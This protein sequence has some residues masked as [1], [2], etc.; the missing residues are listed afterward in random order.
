MTLFDEALKEIYLRTTYIAFTPLGEIH[1]RI[2][3]DNQLLDQLLI[4]HGVNDWCFVTAWNPYSATA[5]KEDNLRWN[6]ALEQELKQSFVVFG[7]IGKGE[8]SGWPAEESFLVIGI[9]PPESIDFAK[10]YQQNAIVVG[11]LKNPATLLITV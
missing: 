6:F 8:D 4:H 1:I 3:H 9:S 10:K 2:G 7:G 11:H 5:S